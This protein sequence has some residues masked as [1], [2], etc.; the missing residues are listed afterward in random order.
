MVLIGIAYAALA[1]LVLIGAPLWATE[2]G[3]RAAPTGI[4]IMFPALGWPTSYVF[5]VDGWRHL[6]EWW[7]GE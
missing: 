5:I 6:R 2:H 7:E 4:R 3:H 1:L